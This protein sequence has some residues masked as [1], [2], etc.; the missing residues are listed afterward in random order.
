M[1]LCQCSKNEV[2]G[3]ASVDKRIYK[4]C[5]TKFLGISCPTKG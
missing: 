4:I 1:A 3:S 5:W 2:M